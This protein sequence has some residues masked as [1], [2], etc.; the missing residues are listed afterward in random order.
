MLVHSLCN[1]VA[2]FITLTVL[3]LWRRRWNNTVSLTLRALVYD[4]IVEGRLI[5]Q[6]QQQQTG[7]AAR[8]PIWLRLTGMAATF[9]GKIPHCTD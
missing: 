8:T 2:R 1:S 5:K 3:L 7:K 4:P 6:Q 9:T